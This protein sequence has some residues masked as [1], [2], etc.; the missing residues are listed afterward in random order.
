MITQFVGKADA[1]NAKLRRLPFNT[2]RDLMYK[3][4][5]EAQLLFEGRNQYLYA[6]VSGPNDNF[7]IS[8]AYWTAVAEQCRLRQT[9]AY[10][11]MSGLVDTRASVI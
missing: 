1:E 11:F 10:W 4:P 5:S 6:E 2:P 8:M 3:L 9:N 7:E